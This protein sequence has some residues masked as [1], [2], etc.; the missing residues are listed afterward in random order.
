MQGHFNS[1]WGLFGGPRPKAQFDSLCAGTVLTVCALGMLTP[2]WGRS[3][4]SPFTA[5]IFHFPGHCKNVSQFLC[6]RECLLW[7]SLSCRV[8]RGPNP[9]VKLSLNRHNQLIR[10]SK[11]SV[12]V[13][14]QFSGQHKNGSQ[15]CKSFSREV[16]GLEAMTGCETRLVSRNIVFLLAFSMSAFV[17]EAVKSWKAA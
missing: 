4:K 13:F 15:V 17:R 9:E 7:L 14:P 3:G 1:L 10:V 16:L 2:Y 5:L 8:Q 12:P 11:P 6:V